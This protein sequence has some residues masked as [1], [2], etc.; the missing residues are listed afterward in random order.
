MNQMRPFFAQIF[1]L[2]VLLSRLLL[3][4]DL[5]EKSKICNESSSFESNDLEIS[6][7]SY[8]EFELRKRE[9]FE[10]LLAK[11]NVLIAPRRVSAIPWE[12]V[13]CTGWPEEVK[14]AFPRD[15]SLIDVS[16]LEESIIGIGFVFSF[17]EKEDILQSSW[18][19][20][21]ADDLER[22]IK[23]CYSNPAFD[24]F[25]RRYRIIS[26]LDS[27]TFGTVLKCERLFDCEPCAVKIIYK[28]KIID[29]DGY[30]YNT[31]YG[32]VPK[33]V[34]FL[35][36]ISHSGVV[37]FLDYFDDGT[38][39]FMV[40]EVFGTSWNLLN[41]ELNS[42]TNPTLKAYSERIDYFKSVSHD[43]FDCIEAHSGFREEI[44][45]FIFYQ[46]YEIVKYLHSIGI[47]HGDLKRE[48]ILIDANYR[49]KLVD[50]GISRAIAR[51][52]AGNEGSFCGFFGTEQSAAPEMFSS[53]QETPF[54]ASEIETWALGVLLYTLKKGKA[55]F[56]TKG[57]VMFKNLT[58]PKK[59]ETGK[60][61][62]FNRQF[63]LLFSCR[64]LRFN[65]KDTRKGS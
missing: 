53:W 10:V 17:C 55:P 38:Y 12:I 15:W 52:D 60:H 49:V 11:F 37:K 35:A 8:L 54:K 29:S 23:G 34:N 18:D 44:I 24:C 19:I 32:L 20:W 26:K 65:S 33:E 58:F 39:G 50:F 63:L 2:F 42:R 21:K 41:E 59:D 47:C 51:D 57:D 7:L 62:N 56:K 28:Q 9:I 36:R 48:N 25:L 30:K 45:H 5:S 40:T 31:E 27:G 61:G 14:S 43:L 1:T 3:C 13:N 4:A 6:G 46:L 64:C 16:I 22:M